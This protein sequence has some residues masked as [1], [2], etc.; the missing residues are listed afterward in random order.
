[1]QIVCFYISNRKEKEMLDWPRLV[2]SG[3]TGAK[4]KNHS[5]FSY[6]PEKVFWF[7][8]ISPNWLSILLSRKYPI[9]PARRVIAAHAI[10]GSGDSGRARSS[11]R[12]S[13]P[14][15]QA[16]SQ[17]AGVEN[18]EPTDDSGRQCTPGCRHERMA[19]VVARATTTLASWFSFLS[20][21]AV[22]RRLSRVTSRA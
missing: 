6:V 12:T 5:T 16:A 14:A 1:M 3:V 18:G 11:E 19:Y 7:Q 10:R 2:P 4:I 15:S 20:R 9:E 17:P 21:T 22:A 13:E 8:S